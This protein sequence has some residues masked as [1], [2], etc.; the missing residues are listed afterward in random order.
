MLKRF[1]NKQYILHIETDLQ[2]STRDK[3]EMCLLL[4]LWRKAEQIS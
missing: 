2:F 4:E 1:I 3:T